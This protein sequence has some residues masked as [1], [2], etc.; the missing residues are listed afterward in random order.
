MPISRQTNPKSLPNVQT[1]GGSSLYPLLLGM[2]ASLV[3]VIAEGEVPLFPVSLK[4]AGNWSDIVLLMTPHCEELQVS[5]A[6]STDSE[7]TLVYSV[8][9]LIL[10]VPGVHI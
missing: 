8:V 7:E 1:G 4:V 10:A 6:V 2:L 9:V 3:L 5:V